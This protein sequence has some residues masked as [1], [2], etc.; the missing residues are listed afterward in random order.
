MHNMVATVHECGQLRKERLERAFAETN[1]CQERTEIVNAVV[2]HEVKVG[3]HRTR[4]KLVNGPVT[5]ADQLAK[6]KLLGSSVS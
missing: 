3:F 2:T 1:P 4:N 5:V 6:E